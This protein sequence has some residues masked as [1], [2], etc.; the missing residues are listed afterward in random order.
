MKYPMSIVFAGMLLFT[1]APS[2]NETP[3]GDHDGVPDTA[4]ECPNT[5]QLNKLPAD[6]KFKQAV[7][8]ERLKPG[9]QAYPVMANGCEPDT[10]GDGVVNSQDWCPNDTEQAISQG[11]EVNGCPRQSDGDGTPDF[12]DECP[13]TPQGTPTDARGCPKA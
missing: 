11:V 13:N 10:D 12:R 5:A 4:D 9:P 1:G 2:A 3:D 6:F 7:N 8:P